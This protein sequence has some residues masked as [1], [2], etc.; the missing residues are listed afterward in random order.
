MTDDHHDSADTGWN[1]VEDSPMERL[2]REAMTARTN[3]VTVAS[4]RPA[5]PPDGRRRRNRPLYLAA[6][7]ML[8]AAAVVIGVFGV[9]T[10][11]S[12]DRRDAP[13]AASLST[14]PTPGVSQA[15]TASAA[16]T[17]PAAQTAP[18]GPTATDA[19]ASAPTQ[20]PSASAS[21]RSAHGIG[22]TVDGLSGSK[23]LVPG[24]GPVAF[25]V[26][27][28]NTTGQ[29]YD[30]VAP[31]V[32]ARASVVGAGASAPVR[33]RLQRQDGGSWTDVP[34]SEASA[35]YRSS[36]DAVAFPLAA[37]A[38]RTIR[39]RLDLTGDNAAGTLSI[40]SF[41]LVP[42]PQGP[43]QE[44]AVVTDVQLA[45]AAPT[46]AAP[47]A[48]TVRL[49]GGPSAGV[50]GK[51]PSQFQ[52]TAT[53]PGTAPLN[54]VVPSVVLTE[55]LG[56]GATSG[57]LKPEEVTVEALYGGTWRSLGVSSAGG[58]RFVVD[59]SLLDRS[60]AGGADSVFDLRLNLGSS[61]LG[62]GVDVTLSAQGDGLSGNSVTV[63][64]RFSYPMNP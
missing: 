55:R 19:P 58:G 63:S 45:A 36:G 22:I 62:A 40:E 28:T 30:S 21:E 39:Y 33:G 17:A 42:S 43:S 34:L 7:P 24:S 29:R 50:T 46:K 6:V 64:P 31:V 20:P 59:T 5:A 56:P 11:T 54:S 57:S 12:A 37:G 23:P 52:L 26:T 27:W 35:D 14:G 18:P 4:L 32:A 41:A 16:S 53:N 8:A 1:A 2:L 15:P 3:Q 44:A 38:G 48:P 51:T 47:V 61:Y 9:H 25:S 49:T 10:D 13:P 60:V